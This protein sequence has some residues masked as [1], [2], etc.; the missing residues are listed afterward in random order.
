MKDRPTAICASNDQQAIG[1][2]KAVRDMDG[3][4]ALTG[5]DN[6][7]ISK[8]I[9]ITSFDMKEGKIGETAAEILLERLRNKDVP[10]KDMCFMPELIIRESSIG[11]MG[12]A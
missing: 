4:I 3:K 12:D 7:N 11:K 10:Y 9:G 8:I 5:L 2:W 1:C 6:L